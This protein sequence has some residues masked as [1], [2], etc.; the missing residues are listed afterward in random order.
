MSNKDAGKVKFNNT[1]DFKDPEWNRDAYAR[2]Q[3]DLDMKSTRYGWLGGPVVGVVPGEKVR[4]LFNMEGFST[5]RVIPIEGGYRQLRHELVVYK[6]L[7]TGKILKT[8]TNPYTNEAVRV[9]PIFNDPFN[10]N[11]TLTHPEPWS[12]GGLNKEKAPPGP[13]LLPW[14]IK[15]DMLLL[16]IDVHFYYPNA[17]QPDKWP[18]ESAGPMVQMSEFYR[19]YCRLEDMK[20]PALT[21]V[22]VW[23]VWGRITP[24]LP[25]MLMGTAPGHVMYEV[26]FA[27]S[28]RPGDASPELMALIEAE[29]PKLLTPPESD[30][31]PSLTSL[32]N[33]AQFAKPAPVKTAPSK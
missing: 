27:C 33:Y 2:L 1:M 15:G 31:G 7:E 9:V 32:E 24:W 12:L 5:S 25:W 4:P 6:D 13:L 3:G 29:Y 18:R 8:W 16:S 17:L 20:N 23:G 11:I 14:S 30:Y 10:Y 26:D 28:S 21:Q 22:P 19:H